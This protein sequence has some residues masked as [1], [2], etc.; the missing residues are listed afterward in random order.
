LSNGSHNQ[1]SFSPYFFTFA[2]QTMGRTSIEHIETFIAPL[3]SL[4]DYEE[5]LLI[6]RAV[7]KT[8]NSNAPKSDLIS[9]MCAHA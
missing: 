5:N 6:K 1:T 7:L 9:F 3:G 4:L 2:V 8:R